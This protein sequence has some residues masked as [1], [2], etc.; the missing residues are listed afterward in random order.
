MSNKLSDKQA[1][2]NYRARS[3][4][5]TARHR[6]RKAEQGFVPLT[7]FVRN[8]R[9]DECKRVLEAINNLSAQQEL[10]YIGAKIGSWNE[11]M[12]KVEKLVFAPLFRERGIEGFIDT[13]TR[14]GVPA[15]RD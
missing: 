2:E 4:K 14:P 10:F 6:Q 7:F 8:G 13:N 5:G 1:A 9:Q 12:P 15:K 3:R 11:L